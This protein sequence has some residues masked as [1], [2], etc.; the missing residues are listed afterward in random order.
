MTAIRLQ[1][2]TKRFGENTPEVLRDMADWSKR[3]SIGYAPW[4]FKRIETNRA[5]WSIRKTAGYQAVIDYIK[6]S[7]Y[8]NAPTGAPPAD[9]FNA[10]MN[11]ADQTRDAELRAMF[12]P[13]AKRLEDNEQKIVGELNG[14][15]G[16]P[17]DVGG[18]YQPIPGIAAQ[19]MRP[20]QTFNA[21][22][23]SM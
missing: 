5:L 3:N 20:S 6:G 2:L 4:S 9:A 22:I 23:D 8:P 19:E 18:Y 1:A 10:L 16:K 15:Q 7:E 13:I 17:T 12:T 11:F 14:A 21:I